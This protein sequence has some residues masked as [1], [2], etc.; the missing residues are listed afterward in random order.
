MTTHAETWEQ[1]QEQDGS[2]I[3]EGPVMA[4]RTRE[5]EGRGSQPDY[6]APV[7]TVWD[8][9]AARSIAYRQ[10]DVRTCP[11]PP[12]MGQMVRCYVRLSVWRERVVT[13][14]MGAWEVLDATPSRVAS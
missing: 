5:V 14:G 2:V 10:L 8:G 11:A 6:I 4:V 12:A 3:I 13:S 1:V 7:L 9:Q